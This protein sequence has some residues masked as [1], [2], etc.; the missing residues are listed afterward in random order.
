[1]VWK[2]V[3]R[4]APQII[5]FGIGLGGFAYTEKYGLNPPKIVEDSNFLITMHNGLLNARKGFQGLWVSGERSKA[6]EI[7][8]A[9]T[10][11]NAKKLLEDGNSEECARL[12]SALFIAAHNGFDLE[13]ISPDIEWL[14]QI[15][16]SLHT[17]GHLDDLE[18]VVILNWLCKAGGIPLLIEEPHNKTINLPMT[19]LRNKDS[20]HTDKLLSC[21][22]LTQA[23]G[24]HS[25]LV[26]E[27][28]AE[29]AKLSWMSTF[30]G[31]WAP[32]AP[33]N[34]VV[35][36][37]MSDKGLILPNILQCLVGG[38]R[39]PADLVVIICHTDP[40]HAK[41]LTEAG[42]GTAL[43]TVISNFSSIGE[44]EMQTPISTP[45]DAAGAYLHALNFLGGL[46]ATDLDTDEDHVQFA[47]AVFRLVAENASDHEA[48]V[49]GYQLLLALLN[50][51]RVSM[52]F[53]AEKGIVGLTG[54]ALWSVG[55][56][57]ETL[58]FL[59]GFVFPFITNNEIKEFVK[60]EE[61]QVLAQTLQALMAPSEDDGEFPHEF[62]D[63]QINNLVNE[64]G[65]K[66][67][68][69]EK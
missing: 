5:G 55:G 18:T 13:A 47:D 12:L 30:G 69:E 17:S 50:T 49:N 21:C 39:F 1:M 68:E 26:T 45:I 57:P 60:D 15:V 46:S 66:Q 3:K 65:E 23:A 27:K 53:L 63:V 7:P 20:T 59:N 58:E 19:I 54:Q 35:D 34:P 22:L 33:R 52:K 25:Y 24:F 62:A 56:D 31:L 40:Q 64:D 14:S 42:F 29:Q 48:I 10:L 36:A 51:G 4:S 43:S 44:M 16:P 32:S 9:E 38:P 2:I 61:M 41:A 37:I 28:R 8:V 6:P 11:E 67:D